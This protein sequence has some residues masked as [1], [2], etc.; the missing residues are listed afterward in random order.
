MENIKAIIFDVDGVLT[1]GSIFVDGNGVETKSFNVRDGQL[2]Q[3][4]KNEGYIFGAIS[5]RPS[6]ATEYRLQELHVDFIRL[7]VSDK[8]SCF[9][10]FCTLYNISPD[11]ICYIG[12][13]VIDVTVLKSCGFPVVPADAC[14]HAK[15]IAKIITGACGG[16]GVLREVI[17]QIITANKELNN[18]FFE[19]YNL[20]KSSGL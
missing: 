18:K 14:V 16:K 5:G 17:D 13:D 20:N 11:K 15:S 19:I 9:K 2:I 6:K 3:F 4:M 8:L 10:E 1:D 7:N 12:D